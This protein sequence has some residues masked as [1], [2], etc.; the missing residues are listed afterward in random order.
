MPARRTLPS[1]HAPPLAQA[2]PFSLAQARPLSLAQ[3]RRI[4]LAAQGFG[5]P[6]PA[7][8]V[9][10]RDVQTTITRLAQVQID[11]VNIVRRAHYLPFFSRLGPYDIALIDR[12]AGRAPRRLFEYWGHAASL[13]DVTLEPAL[14]FRGERAGEEA[15]G[16]MRRVAKEYPGLVERVL[17]DLQRDGPLTAREIDQVEDERT[18]EEWGW[19]WSVVKTACEWLFWTG[20]ITAARRNVQ[21]ERVYDLPDRVLPPAIRAVPTPTVTDAHLTL[22]RRAAAAL[23]IGSLACFADYF[24]L[25]TGETATAVATLVGTGELEP[26]RVTGWARQAYLWHAARRPRRITARALVSPFDS[27]V[28]ERRRLREL[29]GFD[30]RIEIYVPAA[31]RRHGY[32]VY[33]FLLGEKFVA[34]ADLKA[35]RAAGVLRV[36]GAWA[37]PGED[38]AYT[39]RELA[40]ELRELADWL[41]LDRVVVG[42]RGDLAGDLSAQLAR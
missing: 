7:R 8:A 31:K 42:E 37:E 13:L 32:Y 38:L 5:V 9:T 16:G 27:L 14:R 22:V 40:G 33:P 26:V 20:E 35:D 19:N 10:M 15:W 23:G 18:P 12:A 25:S 21:F 17:A 3:A 6:R 2:R 29:F 11:S 36:L 39:A 1:A 28:F 4:A 34:R 24:R 41:G 30:Y